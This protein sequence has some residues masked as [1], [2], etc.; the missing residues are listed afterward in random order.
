MS[1]R[2]TFRLALGPLLI[3]AGLARAADPFPPGFPDTLEQRLLACSGCHG[4]HG[5][6]G[7]QAEYY[8]RI[9]G[10]PAGYLYRQLVNFRDGR[11]TYP[12]MV[13]FTRYL[14]D[15]YLQEMASYYAKLKPGY[16]TPI[17]P[18]VNAQAIVRGKT[19]V[20]DGDK[21]KDLPACAACHGASLTGMQP[22]IP[23]LIGLY[24]DYINAQLGAWQRGARHGTEP[25]CMAKIAAK[26]SGTD[27]SAVASYL[28]SLPGTP[29][30]VPDP[31]G[32]RKLPMACGSQA[33]KPVI[34][35]PATTAR[36]GTRGDG[37]YYARVGDCVACHTVRGGEPFAGGLAMPTP[38]GTLY[39]PNITPDP[40]TGIGK[41]SADD[42]WRALH[43]GRSRDGALL[44]P[45]FPFPNYTKVTR[46]D[47]DAIYNYLR[48]VPAVRKRN[49]PHR[50]D[51][52]Y[53]QRTLLRGWRGLYFDAGEYSWHPNESAEWNRGA[54]LVQG[55][56]H[57]DAC[58]TTRNM[59]GATVKG[60]EF[61]GGLIP[62]QNWYAP[63][64]T[65]NREAG[66]GQWDTADVIELLRTGASKRGVVFGP[67]AQ[68]VHDS[69]QY[70]TE[71]DTKAIAVYLK[72][73]AQSGEP[74]APA[75]IRPT[76]AQSRAS[77]DAGAKIYD[78]QCK[79]CHGANGQGVPP[80]Y[81]PLANNQATNMA[82]AANPIRMVLFGG[83]P[84]ATRGNPRPFGM[85]PFA[86]T[87]SDQDVANVVTYIRQSWGNRGDAVNP[88]D[89]A[90]Y[91][92]VPVD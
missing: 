74:E 68:V 83:F 64:L 54:Y 63:S 24:P 65:S 9:A 60:K 12:Q 40:E 85:P 70:I 27:M 75:Q 91:R 31:E 1:N 55:L 25:D 14:S 49:I 43:E 19:L 15:E 88:T 58:H 76:E 38:F 28:A 7:R 81:A 6:G 82:F 22:G 59:F 45:A 84:P 69:L 87:L 90:K 8:P 46:A 44:Y 86:Y 33:P 21:A 79:S 34:I 13:Y 41:W 37:E 71:A 11:R 30:T 16:P 3:V 61:A 36:G 35:E 26:L 48:T 4:K 53:S 66:L 50:M 89:V 39:T 62:Q 73:L 80:A 32:T 17:A 18:S 20:R 78:D 10:K 77:Y 52:P 5:E 67:M 92:T 56:G 51:F 23:G 57:C 47:S 29:S 42:F 72:S 2:P